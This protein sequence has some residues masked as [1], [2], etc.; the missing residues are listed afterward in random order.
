[1]WFI[2]SIERCVASP[3]LLLHPI[4][5]F[6]GCQ[7]HHPS[8][9]VL[10][11]LSSVPSPGGGRFGLSVKIGFLPMTWQGHNN[12]PSRLISPDDV[13]ARCLSVLYAQSLFQTSSPLVSSGKTRD[14]CWK[15]PSSL[16]LKPSAI[17]GRCGSNR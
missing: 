11:F 2:Y 14:F 8:R 7:G 9:L 13:A 5:S 3:A 15:L 16:C 1:M 12:N 10:P 4:I 17:C 6:R